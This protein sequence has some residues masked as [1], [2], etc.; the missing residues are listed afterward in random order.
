MM[1]PF[2]NAGFV[3]V[4]ANAAC[5]SAAAAAV[6]PSSSS[7]SRR[8]MFRSDDMKNLGYFVSNPAW[9]DNDGVAR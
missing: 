8:V 3:A 7:A 6:I 1:A 9:D 4:C 5:G 2:G